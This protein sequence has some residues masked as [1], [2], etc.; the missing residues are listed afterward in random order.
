MRKVV[1]KKAKDAVLHGRVLKITFKPSNYTLWMILSK[2]KKKYYLV[3]PKLFCSCYDFLVNVILR[4]R[5]N[6][7]YHMHA[8][9]IADKEKRYICVEYDDK[10]F[11]K[12]LNKI[13]ESAEKIY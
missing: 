7:C 5:E 2:E 8:Q 9:E 6:K 10:Y 4:E 13:I 11:L 1:F 12:V 3:I